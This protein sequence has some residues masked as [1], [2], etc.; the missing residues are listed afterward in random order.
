[1]K[2]LSVM[3]A[4]ST[5]VLA[6][7]TSAPA[8]SGSESPP[9]T[10]ASVAPLPSA[11]PTAAAGPLD[12]ALVSAGQQVFATYCAV[13]HNGADDTAPQID[14]LHTFDHQ[15]VSTALSENGLMALQSKMLTADQR[16]QVIA[17][18]TA[19]VDMGR[20][21]TSTV[22][23][24]KEEYREGFAYPVRSARDPRDSSEVKR[25]P[26]WA[27][28]KLGD[29]PFDSESWEQRQLRTTIVTRG[30]EA[31]RAIEFLPNGDIFIVERA[32]TLRI[33]RDGKLD[34]K[35]VEGTP[36]I[37]ANLGI[38]TG[39]MDLVL[40]PDFKTNGWV[41]M[42]YH[43]PRGDL[44]S[45]AIYRGKWDGK[46][47]VDG[48]DIF[49]SDDVDT[50]YS[51]LKFDNKG[52]LYA[53]IGGPALGTDA[54]MMRAQKVDDYGGKTLRLNDDG[55]APTDNPFYGRKD[56]NPEVF[57]MGHRINLGLT[58]NPWTNEMWSTEN[59]PYG[60]D[61]VNILRAGGNY[62]WP[63]SSEGRYYS[64][65]SI[66]PDPSQAGITRPHISYIPSIAPS[67]LVFYTGD[68]FPQW[69]G[70]LFV[71]SMR[72]GETP[73]TG[74]IERIVFNNKW[75]PVRNEML[76]LDLH[77]RIR[78]VEQGPDGYLYAIT[79]E[80]ADSVLLKLE[81]GK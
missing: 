57:T 36:K 19:P 48:K 46:K 23:T 20:G 49:V 64:G 54:S 26:S 33:I 59:A 18:I 55:T 39:F 67:G 81:P 1:M 40:H 44:G 37:N 29:G 8:T 7:C 9:A 69:K 16:T 50:F 38:A 17:F 68:K 51:K 71:G 66:A 41:Y 6:S 25:P 77:Q 53:T 65:R 10:S 63:V 13:C 42:S 15:R 75:E 56:A 43:K 62:G 80:G 52:K 60:G 70:N 74:H 5:L 58:M 3:L 22:M 34:P 72:M 30:L 79:D 24:A 11:P 47:I 12:A 14:Q 4:A 78:D 73:R 21:G 2:H 31:P 76:L 28:P 45:N 61:E 27:A 32:G 35:P